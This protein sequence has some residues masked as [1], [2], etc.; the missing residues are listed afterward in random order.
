MVKPVLFNDK[1]RTEWNS[2][3]TPPYV[4]VMCCLIKFRDAFIFTIALEDV[5]LHMK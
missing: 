5:T 3:S 4:F 1:V 2:A